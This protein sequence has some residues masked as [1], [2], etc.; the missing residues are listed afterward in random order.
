MNLH[1]GSLH[2]VTTRRDIK[3]SNVLVNVDSAK[4][5]LI[6]FGLSEK[7]GNKYSNNTNV[8]SKR[9]KSPELLMNVPYDFGV[10]IWS[11]GCVAAALI[12]KSP[13]I[14]GND[15]AEQLESIVS[16]FG[17]RQLLEYIKDENI[18]CKES[19]KRLLCH[20]EGS[21]LL[22]LRNDGNCDR[23]SDSSLDLL[24]KMLTISPKKRISIESSLQHS[25]F[26]AIRGLCS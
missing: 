19:W 25:Y 26:D 5:R 6:D 22:S 20:V 15:A 2:N 14:V 9:Y 21:G 7:L 3:P 13:I 24:S 17:S 16:I 1:S 12:F 11:A 4:L 8:A 10:D 23:C 18:P